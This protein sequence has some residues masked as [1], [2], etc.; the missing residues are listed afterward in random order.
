MGADT[1][2]K[3]QFH[4]LPKEDLRR[5]KEKSYTQCTVLFDTTFEFFPP[6]GTQPDGR[7]GRWVLAVSRCVA[8]IT[9]M[10]KKKGKKELRKKLK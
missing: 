5:K 3:Q 1:I 7:M 8:R 4:S 6:L 10:R 2:G 9:W